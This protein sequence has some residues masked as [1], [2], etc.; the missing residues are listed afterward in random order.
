MQ[1]SSIG[2]KGVAEEWSLQPSLEIGITYD[3]MTSGGKLFQTQA[4]VT[5]KLQSLPFFIYINLIL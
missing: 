4:T 5:P 3:V 1:A 2:T